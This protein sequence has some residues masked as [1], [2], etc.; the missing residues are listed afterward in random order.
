MWVSLFLYRDASF[1]I[2][3]TNYQILVNEEKLLRRVK[4]QYMVL[5][6]AQAIKSSSR[7]LGLH[8][9]SCVFFKKIQNF[10]IHACL[11]SYSEILLNAYPC[12]R[13]CDTFIFFLSTAASAGKLC[14]ALTVEIVYFLLGH[15]YRTIWLSY[16]RFFI[17]SCPL[18]LTAMNS[19][20]SGSQ[21]GTVLVLVVLPS[22]FC[23][24]SFADS[25]LPC[26]YWG[27]CWTWR[28][29]EWTSA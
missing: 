3:I 23:P 4:W 11:I 22:L 26:Q 8:V 19:S 15:Q 27:S 12:L 13:N 21:R 25:S 1:H 10:L 9:A 7:W 2:L 18:C 24:S 29:F 16:G 14:W 17:S 5:D 28:S 6:E 20:T